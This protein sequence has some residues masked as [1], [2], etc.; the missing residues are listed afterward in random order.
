[1]E[2]ELHMDNHKITDPKLWNVATSSSFFENF[3]EADLYKC[4]EVG[5]KAVEVV[6]PAKLNNIDMSSL[7][8]KYERLALESMKA[9]IE[10]WSVHLPFGWEWDLSEPD[11]TRRKNIITSH[12]EL[13]DIASVLKP[14]K[15]VIHASYE[16]IPQE[17]RPHRIKKCKVALHTLTEKADSYGI[18]LAV[19]CLPR[20]CLGNC[21]GEI[22]Q[23]IEGNNKIG[24]CFDLN[25]L[26]VEQNEDFL[27]ELG[28]KIVT[29]HVS[30][31]DRVDERHWMP[32][33]GVTDWNKM[34]HGLSSAAYKGPFLFELSQ[35]NAE[36]TLTPA[37]L[38][39]CWHHLLSK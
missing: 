35:K 4:A 37:D 16:P 11:D 31:Y 15:A 27:N 28:S 38:V 23:L 19:E 7:R 34:I 14:K 30:D 29:L 2:R 22:K 25:H 32:G 13:I 5:V 10:I 3:S 17:E 26:L 39:K 18:Q 24:V 1:M 6:L 12:S 20:T 33:R 9:G 36:R 8:D 21:S